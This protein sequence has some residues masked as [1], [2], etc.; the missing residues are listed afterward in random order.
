MGL[1]LIQVP[2]GT[3]LGRLTIIA[4]CTGRKGHRAFSCRCDCGTIVVASPGSLVRPKHATR[5]CGCLRR[6]K[7]SRTTWKT[8]HDLAH[9]RIYQTWFKMWERCTS[10]AC[11]GYP[12]YGGRGIQ[13]CD[14]WRD[15]R[16][17]VKW[18]MSNGYRDDLTIDRIDN[19]D[20]YEPLNCQ[21]IPFSENRRKQGG[22]NRPAVGLP[23]AP[24]IIVSGI[25]RDI[26]A[27]Q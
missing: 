26:S 18:A 6:E 7:A 9:T 23:H 4:E 2:I 10:T 13:V 5:S 11:K 21:F 15:V 19:D 1:P 14:E 8:S 24:V 12:S 27:N 17:F 20:H 25:A 3:K 22:K 16:T